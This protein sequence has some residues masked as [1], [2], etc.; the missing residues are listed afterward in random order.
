MKI[1]IDYDGSRARCRVTTWN[2]KTKTQ[3]SGVL[4]S[5]DATTQAMV[6]GAFRNIENSLKRKKQ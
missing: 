1:E 6:I 5:W 2:E 3:T 4:S